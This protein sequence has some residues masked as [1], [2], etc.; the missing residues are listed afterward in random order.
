MYLGPVERTVWEE[1]DKF[2]AVSV[3]AEL[4]GRVWEL[5]QELRLLRIEYDAY[6]EERGRDALRRLMG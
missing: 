2:N 3:L 5:E 4:R 6:R 1:L